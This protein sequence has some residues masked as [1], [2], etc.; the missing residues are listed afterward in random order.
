VEVIWYLPAASPILFTDV[1]IACNVGLETFATGANSAQK[2][3]I[4]MAT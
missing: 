4:A 2:S 1:G 3:R